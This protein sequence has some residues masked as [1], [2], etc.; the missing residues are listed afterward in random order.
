TAAGCRPARRRRR[1]PYARRT[2]SR[3][4]GSPRS[5]SPAPAGRMLRLRLLDQGEPD[6]KLE[7]VDP[8]DPYAHPI[9]QL[10]DPAV[11][12][13]LQDQLLLVEPE[14]VSRQG[15]DRHKAVDEVLAQLHE[16]PER[17]HRQDEPFELLPHAAGHE[18]RLL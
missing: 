10:E 16:E 4:A 13:P 5:R 17:V 6:P 12:I 18:R 7:L 14:A 2:R 8:V 3:A 11:P 1:P 15:L 9:A